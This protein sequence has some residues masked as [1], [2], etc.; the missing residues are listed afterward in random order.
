MN[1]KILPPQD[2]LDSLL[3]EARAGMSDAELAEKADVSLRQVKAWRKKRGL[4]IDKAVSTRTALRGLSAHY[5]PTA[6]TTTSGI[7]FECP[8]FVIREPLDYT[9][10]ARACALLFDQ[11]FMSEAQI[12]TATGTR[13][14]DVETALAMWRRH[15]SMHGVKCLGCNRIVDPR[16]GSVC[17]RSCHDQAC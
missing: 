10:Y 11:A 7:E 12:A 1:A 15:L 16:F 6:H 14:K 4:P 9:A 13:T 3:D 5:E 2:A 8:E 17:S